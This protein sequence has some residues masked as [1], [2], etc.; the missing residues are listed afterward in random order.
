MIGEMTTVAHLIA[1]ISFGGGESLLSNLLRE[2]RPG[3]REIV[4]SVYRSDAFSQNLDAAGITHYELL[5]RTLGH[6]ISKI[7]MAWNTPL[8]LMRL[9]Q[10][11]LLLRRERVN[12]LHA[13]GYPASILGALVSRLA[14]MPSVYTHHF[15]RA[16]P[17]NVERFVLGICYRAFAVC[18]GVSK[19]VTESMQRAFP[20]V[21]ERFLTIHN[22]VGLNFF[23]AEAESEFQQLRTAGRALFVQ[24]ARFSSFKNQMLVV[25]SLGRLTPAERSCVRVVFAGEG[26]ERAVVM[27]RARELGLAKETLFLGFVP[28]E[29][30]PGLLACADFGLFPSE[31]EGF[32][33]GA[34]E[35]LAA[36]L[37]VL[38][39]DTELMKEV[40][41]DAGLQL[42]R[43]YFYKGFGMM[44]SHG[45]S[46]RGR[47]EERAKR[48][49]PEQIKNQYVEV[50]RHLG[51][52]CI[53]SPLR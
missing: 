38:S 43:E 17:S 13:H 21:A 1:P 16:K 53:T 23:K 14:S 25:E 39:L 31:N 51:G 40:V 24:I 46:L 22:C 10:L 36:G 50:Y 33:I 8:L 11:L 12:V 41:G 4:I 48:Y 6:G 52:L 34:A 15:Y 18:T 42:S 28:Y 32:G 44:L 30:L 9:P 20:N 2:R 26:V 29:R 5:D 47:A 27:A 7:A 35:C 37:P 45:A 19:V 49:L 3:V